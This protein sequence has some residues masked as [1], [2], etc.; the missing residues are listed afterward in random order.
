MLHQMQHASLQMGEKDAGF[1]VLR[2]F[3]GSAPWINLMHLGYTNQIQVCRWFILLILP[4]C[5]SWLTPDALFGSHLN[6]SMQLALSCN[7]DEPLQYWLSWS[8]NECHSSLASLSGMV[9]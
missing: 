9:V 6:M 3:G 1:C 5:A 2:E 8:G 7:V 4:L